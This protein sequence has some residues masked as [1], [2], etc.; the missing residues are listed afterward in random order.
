MNYWNSQR[1]LNPRQRVRP[2]N[3]SPVVAVSPS[4][5]AAAVSPGNLEV[6]PEPILPARETPV[7]GRKRLRTKQP[8]PNL[9]DP[10]RQRLSFEEQQ[11]R[12]G[13]DGVNT[14]WRDVH[15]NW[16]ANQWR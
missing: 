16:H 4:P 7:S 5:G 3:S 14:H 1:R 12:D 8:D 2:V 10:V 9:R 6:T 15:E 11:S 13:M